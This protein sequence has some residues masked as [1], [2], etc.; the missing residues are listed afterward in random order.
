MTEL[1]A[2]GQLYLA[3][4][5][6]HPDTSPNVHT[7]IFLAPKDLDDFEEDARASLQQVDS[8]SATTLISPFMLQC[9]QLPIIDPSRWEH[10]ATYQSTQL[11]QL[12]ESIEFDNVYWSRK[13]NVQDDHMANILFMYAVLFGPPPLDNSQIVVVDALMNEIE[14]KKRIIS[15]K[16]P[17]IPTRLKI[18]LLYPDQ[19]P[20]V[21]FTPQELS[22]LH[23]EFVQIHEYN[24]F[25]GNNDIW[26]TRYLNLLVAM[27]FLHPG[28]V[29]TLP[30]YNDICQK[31]QNKIRSGDKQER[32]FYAYVLTVLNSDGLEMTKE[33]LKVIRPSQSSLDASTDKVPEEYV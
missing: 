11:A 9:Y 26:N 29:K 20:G 21:K 30:F 12:R 15:S 6:A 2:D 28:D 24:Q 31:L 3:D 33:G 4:L 14:V 1:S 18:G 25:V 16:A 32:R 19:L 17:S 22:D 10:L 23:E 13:Q 5:V 7:P 27:Q 8:Y